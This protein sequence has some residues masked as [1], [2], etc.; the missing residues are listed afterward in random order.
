MLKVKQIYTGKKEE[1]IQIKIII[2]I[3]YKKYI[4]YINPKARTQSK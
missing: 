2:I 4:I 1:K 3:M